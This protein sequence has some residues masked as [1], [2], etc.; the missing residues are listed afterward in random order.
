M[1]NDIL[2]EVREY[3]SELRIRAR[4]AQSEALND[5]NPLFAKDNEKAPQNFIE[6]SYLYM[7]SCDADTGARPFPCPAFWLSPDLR[8]AP[9]SNLGMPTR[10]LRVGETYRITATVRNRGDLIVPSAKVEFSL[11]T[12]AL[13]WDTRFAGKIGVTSGRVMYD[14]V[15]RAGQRRFAPSPVPSATTS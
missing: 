9:I 1:P 10:E 2:T 14:L 6:S 3:I 8:V 13:G 4:E 12:P 11:A 5:L 7:R 15:V